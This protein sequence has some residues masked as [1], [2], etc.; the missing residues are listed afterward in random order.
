[1]T[2]P[3][4]LPRTA[5]LVA[6]SRRWP[7]WTPYAAVSWALLY[8]AVQITWA[9]TD[10][11][12][13]LTP[14]E[15]YPAWSQVLLACIALLAGAASWASLRATGRKA[16]VATET[17]LLLALPVFAMGMA[18]LP[19]HFVT[20][21]SF[22]GIDSGTGLVQVL[23]SCAGATLLLL[24]ALSHHRRLRG[25][26]PRCGQT[27]DGPSHGPLVHPGPS[28]ASKRTRR[29]VYLLM[30]GVL[31]WAGAKTSWTLGGDAL[32]LTAEAWR[33]TNQGESEVARA[34]SS[35]GIDVTV[36][37]AVAGI[38]LLTGLMYQWGQ[39][40]PRWTLVLAGRRVPRLLPLIP[41]RL[42]AVGLSGYGVVLVIYAPLGAMGI[43][44]R[45]EPT[46]G[47]TD[48]S[49]L[50]WMVA[51]GGLAFGG[52]GFGLIVAARSYSAR[53][54]P[55]CASGGRLSPESP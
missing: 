41:A 11:T 53:T 16:R 45:L 52:L 40:F 51:F 14:N 54:R 30:C 3:S 23:L 34:L 8:A 32:G 10:T 50:L 43:L 13:P 18:S 37:A 19:A 20:L 21:V 17:A 6:W 35:V 39:V 27:H 36:L 29:T 25:R 15:P 48:S 38:F 33:E 49:G 47:F 55:V 22:S 24:V 28:T 1:M 9:A 44:P 4:T 31:P 46:G 42:T 2:A 5:R 7:L 26:C 12:V